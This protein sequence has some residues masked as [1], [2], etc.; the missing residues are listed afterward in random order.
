MYAPLVDSIHRLSRMSTRK[1]IDILGTSA[2]EET[3]VILATSDHGTFKIH[4]ISIHIKIERLRFEGD[5]LDFIE[6]I[7]ESNDH[8]V[9]F[10]IR[11]SVCNAVIP[12]H[13]SILHFI[14][15]I[16][17]VS[18]IIIMHDSMTSNVCPIDGISQFV[19]RGRTLQFDGNDIIHFK[20]FTKRFG[21]SILHFVAVIA[22]DTKTE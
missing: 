14:A 3:K 5:T 19:V 15:Q 6:R 9:C 13:R 20:R 4:S 8:F 22:I 7:L 12:A 17:V 10:I 11:Q 16:V 21:V 1:D 2:S 18:S